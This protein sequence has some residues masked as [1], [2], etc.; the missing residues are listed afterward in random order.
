MSKSSTELTMQAAKTY[1]RGLEKAAKEQQDQRRQRDSRLMRLGVVA[2]QLME[3]GNVAL[4]TTLERAARECF[5]DPKRNRRDRAV[6]GLDDVQS[7]FDAVAA[8]HGKSLS[9][10][11]ALGSVAS[12]SAVALPASGQRVSSPTGP[13]ASGPAGADLPKSPSASVVNS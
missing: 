8:R 9:L 3:R 12:A 4:L 10:N 1:M 2:E 7:Y 6:L 5:A 13:N 11:Q